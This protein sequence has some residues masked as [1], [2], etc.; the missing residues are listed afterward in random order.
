MEAPT[1]GDGGLELG[2]L[3][4]LVSKDFPKIDLVRSPP[5][6]ALPYPPTSIMV[7]T[8]NWHRPKPRELQKILLWLKKGGPL[9]CGAC[10]SI[11][12][13][14][15]AS[16]QLGNCRSEQNYSPLFFDYSTVGC[17]NSVGDNLFQIASQVD[18]I[19]KCTIEGAIL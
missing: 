12:L 7:K 19:I 16:L 1:G 5:S 2:I 14:S 15:I 8:Y 9:L 3:S 10:I 18:M 6:L 13:L 17:G 11:C 4:V